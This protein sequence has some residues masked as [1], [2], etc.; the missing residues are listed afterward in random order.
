MH[1]LEYRQKQKVICVWFYE[2]YEFGHTT[3]FT[4]CFLIFY[5]QYNQAYNQGMRHIKTHAGTDETPL[6][7]DSA[8]TLFGNIF[9]HDKKQLV[10]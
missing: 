9:T 1:T 10:G 8:G 7:N 2:C 6:A 5:V 3:L 4:Y